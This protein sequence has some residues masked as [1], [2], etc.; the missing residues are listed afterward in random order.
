M[1][2]IHKHWHGI[3]SPPPQEGVGGDDDDGEDDDGDQDRADRTPP[4]DPS[5]T[6]G[7]GTQAG[8]Q[9]PDVE[10]QEV[11]VLKLSEEVSYK[12]TKNAPNVSNGL[13]LKTLSIGRNM[14]VYFLCVCNFYKRLERE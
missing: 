8:E 6:D 5:G 4:E 1:R 14:Y 2:L 9:Q 12:H 13:E 3:G 11:R 10:G 7:E